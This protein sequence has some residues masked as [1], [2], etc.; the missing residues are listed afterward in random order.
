[1][2]LGLPS[3][4]KRLGE[5]CASVRGAGKVIPGMCTWNLTPVARWNDADN[6]DGSLI[7]R[8][9]EETLPLDTAVAWLVR[10]GG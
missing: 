3:L 2:W 4:A 9:N 6:A 10:G 5:M 8:C 1:M 7:K